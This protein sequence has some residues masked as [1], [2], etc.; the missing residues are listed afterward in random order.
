MKNVRILFICYLLLFS[1]Q[2]INA[3]KG[4]EPVSSIKISTSL[5]NNKNRDAQQLRR[6]EIKNIDKSSL[7]HSQKKSLRKE[8]QAIKKEQVHGGGGIYLSLSAIVI[9]MLLLIILL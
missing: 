9:V 5:L 7:T 3:S 6:L 8:D 1:I 4:T 2:D